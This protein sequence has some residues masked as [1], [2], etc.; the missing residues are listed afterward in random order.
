MRLFASM[1]SK[2]CTVERW[3]S[4]SLRRFLCI[5]NRQSTKVWKSCTLGGWTKKGNFNYKLIP[6]A[7]RTRSCSW[8]LY[9]Y[10]RVDTKVIRKKE[11]RKMAEKTESVKKKK[12]IYTQEEKEYT[13]IYIYIYVC[14]Y[15]YIY[16][17]ITR[18]CAG[19]A[20]KPTTLLS[21]PNHIQKHSLVGIRNTFWVG[22]Y[23]WC[24]CGV[25]LTFVCKL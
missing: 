1:H 19:H 16:F 11:K 18:I 24:T 7:H 21:L 22:D 10:I 3:V 13:Y 6:V 8:A 5:Q 9:R 15:I 17:Y 2:W 20:V 4:L 12:R 23:C 14:V 25:C